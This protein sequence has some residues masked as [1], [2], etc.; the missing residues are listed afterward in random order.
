MCWLCS[1]C[2]WAMWFSFFFCVPPILINPQYHVPSLIVLVKQ[3]PLNSPV[4]PSTEFI[5]QQFSPSSP[6]DLP[7]L[8][9]FL[10]QMLFSLGLCASSLS[11]NPTLDSSK[12][13]LQNVG[14]LKGLSPGPLF[15][16]LYAPEVN[17]ALEVRQLI[18]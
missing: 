17:K 2:H 3:I 15:L 8:P 16:S 18:L 6:F 10:L 4:T 7:K 14:F 5:G 13:M 12:L 1:F 9:H 11:A